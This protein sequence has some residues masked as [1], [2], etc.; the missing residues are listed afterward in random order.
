MQ[1]RIFRFVQPT[2]I[3]TDAAA[4]HLKRE[5]E[6]GDLDFGRQVLKR[7]ELVGDLE[8]NREVGAE[9]AAV[10]ARCEVQKRVF[11]VVGGIG[12]GAGLGRL[13]IVWPKP[14]VTFPPP[15]PYIQGLLPSFPVTKVR[16]SSMPI[17]SK[18]S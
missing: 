15:S 14:I 11:F 12:A 1:S 17:G 8:V 2:R 7:E 4:A 13:K 10:L 6:Q 18:V 3:A 16:A 9:Q 5:V